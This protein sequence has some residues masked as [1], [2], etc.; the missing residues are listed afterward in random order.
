MRSNTSVERIA[1]M[2]GS[3]NTLKHLQLTRDPSYKDQ[4]TSGVIQSLKGPSENGFS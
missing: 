1:S 3:E 4:P 2:A